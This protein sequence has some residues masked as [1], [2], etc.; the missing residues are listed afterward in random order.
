[1]IEVLNKMKIFQLCFGAYK[2]ALNRC[3]IYVTNIFDE[4]IKQSSITQS[5]QFGVE[6]STTP[7][8]MIIE[9]S[10]IIQANTLTSITPPDNTPPS[11][12]QQAFILN[13]TSDD[14]YHP[15]AKKTLNFTDANT[16]N[17]SVSFYHK[18]H[19][20]FRLNTFS[21]C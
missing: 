21:H 10:S 20:I 8:I 17:L 15:K 5:E 6:S 2:S 11:Q 4:G 18:Y 1:M 7:T 13:D 9:D 14:N 19:Y 3:D 12:H 16:K